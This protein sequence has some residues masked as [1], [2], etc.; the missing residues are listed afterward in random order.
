MGKKS[1]RKYVEN[2]VIGL[3]LIG[4]IFISLYPKLSRKMII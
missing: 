1:I 3:R 2:T 4:T